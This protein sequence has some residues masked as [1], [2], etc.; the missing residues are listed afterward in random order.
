M[1]MNSRPET[2]PE[3]STLGTLEESLSTEKPLE[4][5]KRLHDGEGPGG[6]RDSDKQGP[7]SRSRGHWL[8]LEERTVIM[9]P[10]SFC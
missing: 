9:A 7:G 8:S 5:L 1:S 3:L 2:R 4:L 6:G 10:P